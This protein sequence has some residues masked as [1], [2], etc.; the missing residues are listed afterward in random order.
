MDQTLRL[1]GEK[2]R[3][4][5]LERRRRQLDLQEKL[6]QQYLAEVAQ[7]YDLTI[8]ELMEPPEELALKLTVEAY[9]KG[10]APPPYPCE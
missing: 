10:W 5:A 8:E 6:T 3:L 1:V 7:L 2:L 9:D 4:A